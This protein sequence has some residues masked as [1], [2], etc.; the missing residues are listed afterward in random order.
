MEYMDEN[1][2]EDEFMDEEDDFV[3]DEDDAEPDK[4]DDSGVDN[5]NADNEDKIP[6]KD[7]AANA[8]KETSKYKAPDSDETAPDREASLLHREETEENMEKTKQKEESQKQPE[9][10]AMEYVA[11]K[12]EE[13]MEKYKGN[14]SLDEKWNALRSQINS[15]LMLQ[16]LQKD[17]DKYATLDFDYKQREVLKFYLWQGASEQLVDIMMQKETHGE[18]VS[19]YDAYKAA[20]RASGLLEKATMNI[21][22][23]LQSYVDNFTAFKEA[24]TK[25]TNEYEIKIQDMD[26]TIKSKEDEINNKNEEIDNLKNEINRLNNG[27]LQ[28]KKRIEMEKEIERRVNA[29][30]EL[31]MDERKEL[32]KQV[33]QQNMLYDAHEGKK[34]WNI[35]GKRQKKSNIKPIMLHQKEKLPDNFNLSEYMIGRELSAAQME[36]ITMAVKCGVNDNVIKQMIDSEKSS[37]QMKQVL[38]FILAKRQSVQH[39]SDINEEDIIYDEQQSTS[40]PFGK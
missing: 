1:L 33:M 25:H 24:T 20:D 31:R 18:M 26:E 2:A 5:H 3:D 39:M 21:T 22:Q 9:L 40:E 36:V 34:G 29:M 11:K 32:E 14:A 37:A 6:V 30:V 27:I 23:V 35:F 38:E 28:E 15:G 16:V 8:V 19:A 13:F 4:G 7:D 12:H 10:P 17:I